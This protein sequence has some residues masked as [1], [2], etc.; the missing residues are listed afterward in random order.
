MLLRERIFGIAREN[1]R[2]NRSNGEQPGANFN[3][4]PTPKSACVRGGGFPLK[5][6]LALQ[7]CTNIFPVQGSKEWRQIG[8]RYSMHG[9]RGGLCGLTPR[10]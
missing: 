9:N 8:C 3:N 10:K 7:H 6:H 1:A 4:D 5:K 2:E